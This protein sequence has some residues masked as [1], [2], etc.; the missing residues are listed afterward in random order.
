MSDRACYICEAYLMT[1]SSSLTQHSDDF[2]H[3][4]DSL[5]SSSLRFLS[6]LIAWVAGPWAVALFSTWLVLPALALLVALPAV[7]S[8]RNDKRTIVVSTPGPVRVALEVLL[9]T[10]AVIAPLFVWPNAV[11]VMA[12]G[13]VVASFLTGIPRMMW[14]VRGAP[15]MS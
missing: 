3:P 13:I 5:V 6:E 7:F 1:L 12:I 8:T 15:G 10:V 14:L 9:Y 2:R 11:S 4:Y